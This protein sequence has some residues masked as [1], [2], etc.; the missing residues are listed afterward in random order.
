V[1]PLFVLD[2]VLA[3]AADNFIPKTN[4]GKKTLINVMEKYLESL[5]KWLKKSGLKVNNNK[6]NCVCSIKM[7]P[8]NLNHL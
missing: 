5:T 6:T 8:P 1:S 3:F 7:I 2:F 4:I